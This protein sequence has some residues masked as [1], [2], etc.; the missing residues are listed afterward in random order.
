MGQQAVMTPPLRPPHHPPQATVYSG[1]RTVRLGIL[2]DVFALR[3]G[4]RLA[5]PLAGPST[6]VFDTP[7]SRRGCPI[8]ALG[9]NAHPRR[10]VG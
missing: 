2:V 3:S 7:T 6:L 5:H 9:E 1:G 8:C 10:T 4:S